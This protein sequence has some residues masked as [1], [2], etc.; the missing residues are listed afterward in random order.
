MRLF[1]VKQS[2]LLLTLIC[3]AFAKDPYAALGLK[4]GASDDEIKRAYRKLALKYHPDK[5]A[6]GDERSKAKAQALFIE[7]RN[8][9][10]FV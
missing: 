7:V 2:L 8:C 4:R 9:Q 1:W 3:C 5:Q 6:K 10:I